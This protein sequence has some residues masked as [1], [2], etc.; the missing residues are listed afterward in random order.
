MTLFMKR[1]SEKKQGQTFIID[2]IT[3]GGERD[4]PYETK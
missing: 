2:K 1:S 4:I 3:S